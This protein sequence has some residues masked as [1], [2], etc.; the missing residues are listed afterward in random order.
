[1]YNFFTE[2]TKING[3]FHITGSDYNHA[4]NVLR[5]KKGEQ[6][7][8]SQGGASHLCELEDFT[9][10]SVIAK[11]IEENYQDTSLPIEIYL[12]QGLPK[13]DKL[14]L[15]IQKTVELGV[16]SI[17]PVEMKRSIVKLDEKKKDGK[18]ARWQAIAESASKQSKRTSI[19]TV[20]TAISYQKALDKAKELDILIVPYESK[21]GMQ[22]T[23][24]ALQLI[25]AGMKIGVLIGPEGGFEDSE[26][27]K[28]Q[29]IGAKIVSLGKRILRTETASITT[30]AMLMLHAETQ[31]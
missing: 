12:F 9:D 22:D 29:E 2:N 8:V 4:K 26:I 17:I 18:T 23:V 16:H 28:A 27:Q 6:F 11:I 3:K 20:E 7:L 30:V 21:N 1:M 15:I 25:K 5:M 24:D 13:A 19:P 31:L 10:N 14:E